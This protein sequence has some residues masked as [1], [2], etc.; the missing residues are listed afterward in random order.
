MTRYFFLFIL[1]FT[2]DLII[3]D[4]WAIPKITVYFSQ[5]STYMLKVFPRHIPDKYFKWK[6]SKPRKLKNFTEQDTTIIP[7]YAIL[8]KIE[9]DDTIQIWN[10]NLINYIMPVYAI[11][12]ND[13]KSIVTFDNWYTSGYGQ[14]TMVTYDEKGNLTKRY[15]LEDF[16]PFP[17]NDYLISISSIWWRCGARY[18]DEQT[19][20]I[21]FKD[22]DENIKTRL[23]N[24][25]IKDF[26]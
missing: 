11:I 7:C 23:F 16:S 2:S 15:R 10:R 17:I 19:I 6:S 18:I 14:E 21:C 26:V 8:Y 9:R 20:E 12:S 4:T 13:G 25:I 22:K 1:L 24:L 3:A 5:D